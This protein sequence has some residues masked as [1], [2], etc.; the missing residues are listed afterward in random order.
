[1]K[2]AWALNYLLSAKWRLWSDWADLG[3]SESSLGAQ[4]FC[5][6]VTRWLNYCKRRFPYDIMEKSTNNPWWSLNIISTYRIYPVFGQTGLGKQCRPRSDTDATKSWYCISMVSP[7]VS[8]FCACT[9][10]HRRGSKLF[11]AMFLTSIL[12][13]FLYILKTFFFFF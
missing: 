3:W 13:F 1:M 8:M 5:W 10:L 11:S 6:F 4:S 12:I 2:K 9:F 7:L